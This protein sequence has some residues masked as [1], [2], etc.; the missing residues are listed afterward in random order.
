MECNR[1]VIAHGQLM[2]LHAVGL[3]NAIA[4]RP[5][6]LELRVDQVAIEVAAL[7]RVIAAAL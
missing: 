1:L 2:H 5:L 6:A 7:G 4:S 3:G